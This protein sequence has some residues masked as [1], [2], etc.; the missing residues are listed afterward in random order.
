AVGTLAVQFAK[1]RGAHVLATASGRDAIALVRRLGAKGVFDPRS[2]NAI[3]QLKALAPGGI[4]AVLALAGGDML[5]RCIDLVRPGGRVARPNGV[6]PAPKR[7]K[8]V[9]VFAY[10]AVAGRRESERLERAVEE[11]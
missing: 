9:R 3:E 2:K 10:D 5:E 11:A 4:N 7:R 6:E 1:R 8:N